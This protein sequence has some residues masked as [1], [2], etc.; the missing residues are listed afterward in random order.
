MS[1][2]NHTSWDRTPSRVR[3]L[4]I[5]G[6]WFITWMGLVGGLFDRL[7]FEYVVIFSALHAIFFLVMNTF[8]IKPFPVQVRI[9][10]FLWVAAG[11]YVPHLT[12]LM[13]ITLAGL[14]ANLF[15][16]YCPLARMMTLMPWNRNERFSIGLVGSVFLSPP[17][18]GKFEPP[19]AS[20]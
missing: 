17:M 19:A 6:L 18:P 4:L 9:A 5:W 7:Y 3:K 14:T 13:Y 11:T 20:R 1:T 8:N 12:F 2:Q 10:Y 15:L 16:G